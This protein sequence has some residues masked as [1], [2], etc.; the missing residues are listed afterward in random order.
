MALKD[1]EFHQ[2]SPL[3][4]MLTLQSFHPLL[5][6]SLV[7]AAAAAV[8][9]IEREKMPGMVA[10]TFNPSTREAEAGGFLVDF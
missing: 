3:G 9:V 2:L 4:Q 1:S 7:A 10:H 5:K 8:V 6:I